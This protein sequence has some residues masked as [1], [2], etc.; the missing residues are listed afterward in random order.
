MFGPP[1]WENAK[2]LIKMVERHA[3]FTIVCADA[4][5]VCL[6]Q[7][8][9]MRSEFPKNLDFILD[10]Y[11]HQPVCMKKLPTFISQKVMW[12]NTDIRFKFISCL[13]LTSAQFE[14][15]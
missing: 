7:L 10:P 12:N 3:C 6:N 2:L 1:F 15:S 8:L 9:F 4:M 5:I 11:C 13:L 14:S